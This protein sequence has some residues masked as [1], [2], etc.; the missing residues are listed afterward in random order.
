MATKNR[1]TFRFENPGKEKKGMKTECGAHEPEGNLCNPDPRSQQGGDIAKSTDQVGAESR[2]EKKCRSWFVQ[3]QVFTGEPV[4]FLSDPCPVAFSELFQN[5]RRDHRLKYRSIF[6]CRM[7]L[8]Q[9]LLPQFS[10]NIDQFPIF[11]SILTFQFPAQAFGQGRT[12]SSRGDGNAQIPL[13]HNGGENE[14]ATLRIV[15]HVDGNPAT[16]AIPH[17]LVVHRPVVRGADHHERT[18]QTGGG[19]PVNEALDL[20]F[21]LQVLQAFGKGLTDDADRGITFEQSLDFT[22]GNVAAADDKADFLSQ[23]KKNGVV[24]HLED[25]SLEPVVNGQRKDAIMMTWKIQVA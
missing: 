8:R 9:S 5:V 16:P 20:S 24:F 4:D 22:F 15:H 23:V 6:L 18:V 10:E 3:F 2:F 14:I 11:R 21:L 7:S 19:I 17:H 1:H 12:F 13:L 25:K